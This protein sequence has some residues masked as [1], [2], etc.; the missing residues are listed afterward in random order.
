MKCHQ[1]L[2]ALSFSRSAARRRGLAP[3]RS[4]RSSSAVFRRRRRGWDRP[5]CDAR[6]GSAWQSVIRD[7]SLC[8]IPTVLRTELYA[9]AALIGA[10]V[11]VIGTLLHVPS[12]AAPVR[13][14]RPL[15]WTPVHGYATR[16]A[17]SDACVPIWSAEPLSI[18]M[19]RRR[20]RRSSLRNGRRGKHRSRQRHVDPPRRRVAAEDRESI[21]DSIAVRARDRFSRAAA[22]KRGRPLSYSISRSAR[23]NTG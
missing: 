12:F 7:T 1:L 4:L 6:S 11:V 15:L 2:V 17:A 13:R 3:A 5:R 10:A 16:L 14:R 21:A 22:S 18:Y 20:T 9:V 23:T 8:Q 19:P